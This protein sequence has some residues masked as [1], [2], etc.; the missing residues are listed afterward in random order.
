M[1]EPPLDD[2]E[3]ERLRRLYA[4]A[5]T[6]HEGNRARGARRGP[7]L[8]IAVLLGLCLAVA[9]TA[10]VDFR[11]LATPRGTALAWTNA[12]VFGDC[13]TYRRLSVP[14][15]ATAPDRRTPDA[16]CRDLRRQT[17]AAR[18]NA[19]AIGID[20]RGVEQDGDRA[21]VVVELRRP[22][23]DAQVRLRLRRDGDDWVVVRTAAT[24]L[25][26]GCA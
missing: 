3:S 23:G 9:V 25:A 14:D 19:P 10:V 13:P 15:P 6:K 21:T 2:R 1:A 18:S 11:R 22:S 5:E 8:L 7:V 16:L 4:R 24:C 20:V 17:D 26:V 12:A